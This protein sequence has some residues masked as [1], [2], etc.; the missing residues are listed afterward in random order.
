[1]GPEVVLALKLKKFLYNKYELE[2]GEIA[3]KQIIDYLYDSFEKVI[4]EDIKQR[5]YNDCVKDIID[6]ISKE[7]VIK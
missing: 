5:I 7:N 2:V 6:T 4:Y 3:S 1:M